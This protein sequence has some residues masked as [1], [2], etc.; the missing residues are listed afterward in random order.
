MASDSTSGSEPISTL[1]RVDDPV[2][3]V[4]DDWRITYLND[5]GAALLGTSRAELRGD[6][7]WAAWPDLSS[8]SVANSLREASEA[9]TPTT[10]SLPPVEGTT[11]RA[12]AHPS[13][14]GVTLLAAPDEPGADADVSAATVGDTDRTDDTHDPGHKRRDHRLQRYETIVETMNDGVY[15]VDRDG[16]FTM[17]NREYAEMTGYD[18]EELL[19]AHVSLVIDEETSE[20]AQTLEAELVDGESTVPSIEAPL[21]RADGST[22][23]AEAR[24]ALIERDGAS[25]RIGVVRDVSRRKAREQELERRIDQQAYVAE[26]SRRA[27]EGEDLDDLFDDVVATVAETLDAE[28]CKVLDLEDGGEAL[29]LRAGVGWE[30]G[31]V[32]DAT[33]GVGTESQAGYTLRSAEPVVVDDLDAETRFSGPPLL[34]DHGVRSGISVV[35]GTVEEPWGVLGTHDTSPRA[36]D[37]EDVSFVE[38]VANVLATAIDRR[39]YERRLKRYEVVTEQST[40]VNAIV[41]SDGTITYVTPSV[42][43]VLGYEPAEVVGGNF[44]DCLAEERPAVLD[45]IQALLDGAVSTVSGELTLPRR[46]GSEAIMAVSGR[47][48]HDDPY[49]DGVVV[50][51]HDVTEERRQAR[52]LRDQ[53]DRLEALVDLNGVVSDINEVIIDS[54]TR[55]ALERRVCENLAAADS[56]TFAWTGEVDTAAGEVVARASA[57]PHEGYLDEI[58]IPYREGEA[59]SGPTAT[60]LQTGEIQV[61]QRTDEYEHEA[62][63]AAA[64]DAGFGSSAA[65]PITYDDRQYGVL[66]LYSE[67]E[68]AF[69]EQERTVISQLGESMGHAIA[70]LERKDALMAESAVELELALPDVGDGIESTLDEPPTLRVDRTIPYENGQYLLYLTATGLDQSSVRAFLEQG[71]DDTVRRFRPVESDDGVSL[72]EVLL[73]QPP[74]ISSLTTHGGVVREVTIRGQNAVVTVELPSES[75]VRAAVKALQERYSGIS[76]VTQRQVIRESRSRIEYVSTVE[77]QLTDRQRQTLETAYFAGYY[78][79]PRSST[80]SDVAEVLAISDA[81]VSQHLRSGHEKLCAVLFEGDSTD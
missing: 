70:S 62:W 50:Y 14:T 30:P 78:D 18:R 73:D 3:S 25:E 56:Y 57:G 40:D 32:G 33:V 49:V 23:P 67:R 13:E 53:R 47:N 59:V 45:R 55:A 44:F 37:P 79:W 58:T 42:E 35:I 2:L 69:N 71:D 17:V 19:G 76:L 41:D 48:L 15:T 7:L 54:Q 10:V 80:A 4:D 26:L 77:A 12:R 39:A 52:Q 43:E 5:A 75:D 61:L 74:A 68:N 65:I 27:L 9:D 81:T 38:S 6:H 20:R 66:N 22:F 34:T 36:Y 24:F 46:D 21:R 1:Q 72:Y 31:Y 11:Y 60:A 29:L 51:T 63:R 64:D 16:H 8:S 28:F